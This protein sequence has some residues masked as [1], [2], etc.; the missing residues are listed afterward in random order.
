M[1]SVHG[2]IK[3]IQYFAKKGARMKIKL[4]VLL[5]FG[6]VL[7]PSVPVHS[8]LST[9]VTDT[10]L[11]GSQEVHQKL[12]VQAVEIEYALIT[13][14]KRTNDEALLSHLALQWKGDYIEKLPAALYTKQYDH[15]PLKA[16]EENLVSEGKWNKEKQ[17]L[18]FTLRKPVY[19][20]GTTTFSLV[21]SVTQELEAKIKQ[22]S[23]VIISSSLPRAFQQSVPEKTLI[24]SYNC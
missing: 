2:I 8:E 23:F 21:F 4:L 19:L 22:G 17:T 18:S 16:L 6:Q 12:G 1:P 13:F 15:M 14:T 5:L 3:G 20:Y 24:L 7:E 9:Q 11:P 10:I